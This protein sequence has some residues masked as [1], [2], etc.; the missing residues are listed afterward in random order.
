MNHRAMLCQFVKL[1][2]RYCSIRIYVVPLLTVVALYH[3][4]SGYGL[5]MALGNSLFN[6]KL[7]INSV[8]SLSITNIT[9]TKLQDLLP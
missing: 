2:F 4:L 8:K 9:R 7:S 5:C 1:Y 6:L 3:W